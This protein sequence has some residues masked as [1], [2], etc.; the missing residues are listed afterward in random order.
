M[1]AEF[2]KETIHQLGADV[3]GIANVES[4]TEAPQGFHPTDILPEAKSVIVFG[5]QF[6]KGSFMAK[7]KASYTIVRNQLV[8]FLDHLA[9]EASYKMEEKGFIAVSIPS[10][11]PYEYWDATRRHGRGIL[12]LKHS[13]QLAGLGSIG[14]NTL[15]INQK[16]GNRLWLGAILTNASLLADAPS[17]KLCPDSCRKCLDACPQ[18]ALNGITIDQRKCREVSFTNT[19][20]G[21]WIIAC[22]ECRIK[23][24]FGVS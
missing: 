1:N 22:K 18:S 5:K 19:E 16:Y 6:P 13:A 17:R 7:S 9:L 21:G 23:C 10:T 24:P 3:C 11:D 12:S 14:K 8:N 4:F 15:L 2:I 20:G